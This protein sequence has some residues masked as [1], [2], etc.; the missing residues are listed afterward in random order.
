M[1]YTKR[2][3]INRRLLPSRESSHSRALLPI[4]SLRP[5]PFTAK[6]T[7]LEE[8]WK[9]TEGS[10][11]IGNSRTRTFP[12]VQRARSKNRKESLLQGE[13]MLGPYSLPSS[14]VPKSQWGGHLRREESSPK[15]HILASPK[16]ARLAPH[17]MADA[18]CH[19]LLRPT[20]PVTAPTHNRQTQAEARR[21]QTKNLRK[22]G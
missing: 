15:T 13:T 3:S 9:E 16:P 14:Q 22:G 2:Y 5:S 19:F 10:N 4:Y 20:M 21:P 7:P 8:D 18:P 12:V 11:D 17:G 1:N 6:A